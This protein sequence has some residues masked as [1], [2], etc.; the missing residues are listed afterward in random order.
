[1]NPNKEFESI[2]SILIF[3][4]LN[5]SKWL[6]FAVDGVLSIA[7]AFSIKIDF[8][9][10]LRHWLAQIHENIHSVSACEKRNRFILEVMDYIFV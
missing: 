8:E 2:M 9:N 10:Y 3:S 1:M 6:I 7:E 4:R 5:S